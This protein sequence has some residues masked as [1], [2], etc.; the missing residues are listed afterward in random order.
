MKD[1]ERGGIPVCTPNKNKNPP[2]AHSEA[3]TSTEIEVREGEENKYT[4]TIRVKKYISRD[5]PLG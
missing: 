4:A 5:Y 3:T 1:E 2:R